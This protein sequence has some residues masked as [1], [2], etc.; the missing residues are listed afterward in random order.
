MSD[1]P[2]LPVIGDLAIVSIPPISGTVAVSNFPALQLITGNVGVLNFP[3]IQPVSQSGTWTTGRTWTLN[4]GTD[5][6]TIAG[7]PSTIAVTQSGTWTVG[8]SAGA[9]IIGA[10]TQSGT[11]TVNQGS[12]NSI[13]NAWPTKLTNGTNTASVNADGSLN[14]ANVTSVISTTA[15]ITSITSS[16][17]TQT[18]LAVN[19]ARKG[20]I[21]FNDSTANCF[22]AFAATA[23]SSAFTLFLNPNMSYQNE[24][25]IYTGVISAIWS[26]AN[27]FLR[28]TEL[29]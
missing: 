15:A 22:I 23:S 27:G 16:T 19:A 24:A 25:I 28:V 2:G 17:S 4:S 10:V 20:F 29:S 13:G 7:F 9:N 14:V 1:V 21:V 8:L 5:S 6:V 3:A 11:W 12:A 26:A 18:V